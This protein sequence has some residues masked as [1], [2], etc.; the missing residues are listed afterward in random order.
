DLVLDVGAQ[1]ARRAR[2]QRMAHA[3][4]D[5]PALPPEADL[6][7]DLVAMRVLA[8]AAP[9][10]D[11]LVAH[12]ELAVARVRGRE[13]GIG[14]AVGG[15]RLP[16]GVA[17]AGLDHGRAASR[18]LDG[19]HDVYPLLSIL[20]HVSRSPTLRLNTSRAGDESR[21]STQK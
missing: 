9:G 16:E 4:D 2:H 7:L 19:A 1:E 10:R 14:M 11:G 13:L 6:Q 15:H 20:A 18:G 3:V 21:S 5:H 12:R 8:H 17:L